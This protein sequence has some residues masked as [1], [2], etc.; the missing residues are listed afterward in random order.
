MNQESNEREDE[1]ETVDWR[2]SYGFITR[3]RE[4]FQLFPCP[5]KPRQAQHEEEGPQPWSVQYRPTTR[6]DWIGQSPADLEL[7]NRLTKFSK[8]SKAEQEAIL[9]SSSRSNILFIGPAHSGKSSLLSILRHLGN[10]PKAWLFLEC[11]DIDLSSSNT[12]T[13][14]NAMAL[15]LPQIESYYQWHVRHNMKS[16]N[17][18]HPIIVVDNFHSC[19]PKEQQK[20]KAMFRKCQTVSI[21]FIFAVT[22]TRVATKSKSKSQ[23]STLV[24]QE[25]L[26]T[27]VELYTTTLSRD[28]VCEKYLRIATRVS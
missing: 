9:G 12:T 13:T 4:L 19:T 28:Q 7:L 18:H 21:R 24:I 6:S 17:K 11:P 27:C 5:S 14:N 16:Q 1:V 10:S 3:E 26:D 22:S 2:H 15:I 20:F 25:I 8:Y 23:A